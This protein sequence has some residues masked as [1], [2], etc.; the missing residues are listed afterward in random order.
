VCG[1]SWSK[2]KLFE[3]TSRVL[4]SLANYFLGT[5][6]CSLM[7]NADQENKLCHTRTRS[8][9]MGMEAIHDDRKARPGLR[10][11]RS[12]QESAMSVGRVDDRRRRGRKRQQRRGQLR[13]STRLLLAA[14]TVGVA[15]T[16]G[17][18][19]FGWGISVA[20]GFAG[21]RGSSGSRSSTRDHSSRSRVQDAHRFRRTS[22]AVRMLLEDVSLG[23][24][25][26]KMRFEPPER[27]LIHWR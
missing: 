23:C 17:A 8:R 5:K 24:K 26:P 9:L 12:Q 27:V 6:E 14:C 22:T 10:R 4:K 3:D 18:D 25:E 11:S 20:L 15:L 21:P 16:G 2:S 19:G 1:P 13:R 7:P